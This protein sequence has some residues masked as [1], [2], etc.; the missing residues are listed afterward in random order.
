MHT[1]AERGKKNPLS[2]KSK[3][4]ASSPKGRAKTAF[5]GRMPDKLQFQYTKYKLTHGFP[6]VILTYQGSKFSKM[7]IQ[8]S[9]TAASKSSF[10]RNVQVTPWTPQKRRTRV[11]LK[12]FRSRLL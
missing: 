7:G 11:L 5:G 6:W 1:G 12:V 10:V 3:I 2:Q 9:A 8:P 4:F